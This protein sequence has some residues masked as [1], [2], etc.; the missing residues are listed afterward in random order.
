[1]SDQILI[2]EKSEGVGTITLNRP[3]VLNALSRDVYS[4]LDD[5]IS[6]ME[7][8]DDIKAVIFTGSGERAFS[9]GADIHEMARLAEDP[10]PPPPDPR[11]STYAW[12]VAVC[13]KPTIGAINGLAYGGG[14]VMAS[15]FDIRVGCERSRFKFLAASYG[16]V[17]STWSLPRQVGWPMAKEL[18]FTARVVEAEE[19][20]RIGLLNHLVDSDE[21]MPKAQELAQ[22]IAANDPRMVQG[23][24]ELLIEDVG[25]SWEQTHRNE[26]EAQA[27]RLAP[28]PV[29]EG[30]KPFLDRKGRR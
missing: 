4:Q 22:L 21:L 25:A 16:R 29:L 12:H 10:N 24:K 11:R 9:A 27:G 8:D 30:F 1:M 2:V 20:H 23:I 3:D 19:A 17:N 5:A 26:A 18:L 7:A 15:S 13:S 28:T 14:A 6:D